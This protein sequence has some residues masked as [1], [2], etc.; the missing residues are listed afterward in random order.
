MLDSPYSY[1]TPELQEVAERLARQGKGEV[2]AVFLQTLRDLKVGSQSSSPANSRGLSSKPPDMDAPKKRDR[3]GSPQLI[4]SSP[5]KK[6]RAEIPSQEEPTGPPVLQ[7]DRPKVPLSPRAAG[8]IGHSIPVD[9]T[10]E[11][12]TNLTGL[13][14]VQKTE[15][16]VKSKLVVSVDVPRGS[17]SK[18]RATE[19]SQKRSTRAKSR[20]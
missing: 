17:R 13:L 2:G 6:S 9:A 18:T 7:N 3:E 4:P 5:T 15:R 14:P 16:K 19:Q 20:V 8:V 11:S 10:M 1:L 12:K